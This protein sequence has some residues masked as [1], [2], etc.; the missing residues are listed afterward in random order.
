MK[1]LKDLVGVGRFKSLTKHPRFKLLDEITKRVNQGRLDT[2]YKPLVV[3]VIA[4]KTAH[5][6]L[7]DLDY[8]LKRMSQSANPGKVFFGSLKSRS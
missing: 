7:T 4:I 2:K 5:L 3:K 6:S 8:L 1:E